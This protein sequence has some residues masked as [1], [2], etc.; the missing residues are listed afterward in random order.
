[1]PDDD[2]LGELEE[3][4]QIVEGEEDIEKGLQEIEEITKDVSSD[5]SE[6]S[7]K[8]QK[9]QKSETKKETDKKAAAGAAGAAAEPKKEKKSESKHEEPKKEKEE[10]KP[11]P[12]P[13]PTMTPEKAIKH[14]SGFKIASAV[15][16]II[17][18]AIYVL[19]FYL[20][21]NGWHLIS[22]PPSSVVALSG[23]LLI[24]AGGEVYYR[25]KER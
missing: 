19:A 6:K 25:G 7:E 22:Y 16:I 5:T 14:G 20:R 15:L 2:I 1:M 3:L 24:L 17:G 4:S 8:K 10:Q 9:E 11:Q 13:A 18:F 21:W 12:K 23:T